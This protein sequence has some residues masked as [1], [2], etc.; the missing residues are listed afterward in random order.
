MTIKPD[1]KTGTF[2]IWNRGKI[3][4]VF[5]DKNYAEMYVRRFDR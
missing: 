5:Y 4:R 2:V 3:E 1:K